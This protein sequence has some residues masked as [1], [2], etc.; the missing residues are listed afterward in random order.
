M[1]IAANVAGGKGTEDIGSYP[2]CQLVLCDID[3]IHGMRNSYN[4]FSTAI[5]SQAGLTFPTSSVTSMSSSTSTLVIPEDSLLK[6]IDQSG[7]LTHC[8]RLLSTSVFVA[9]K[10]HHEKSSVLVHCSDGW[11]RTAQITS[12]TQLIL[13]PY[14]RTLEGFAVLIEKEWCSFGHKFHIRCGHSDTFDSPLADQRSPIF[15]QFLHI[16][17]SILNQFPCSFEYSEYLLIF[18]ADHLYSGL[19]GNF[20]GNS[21]KERKYTLLVE[22]KTQSIWSY[23]L[24]NK[25][26]FQ[27]NKYEMVNH[28]LWP[29]CGVSKITLWERYM[30]RWNPY[31]HPKSDN[32]IDYWEDDL[33]DGYIMI[34]PSFDQNNSQ[35]ASQE[36]EPDGF[37]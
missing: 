6:K 37:L 32:P 35:E 11:D 10:L 18:I 20:L 21:E 9:E 1:A 4:S 31:A 12:L 25:R 22:E 5:F 34:P 26:K 7:W 3:N 13:D 2:N 17:Q 36:Y 24:A 19:F 15:I 23:I 28:P 14:Y 8:S 27:N 33:G 30:M 16:V 29:Y